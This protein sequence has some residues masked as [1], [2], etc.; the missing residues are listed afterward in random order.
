MYNALCCLQ[1]LHTM[2]IVHRD[3]KPA[4]LLIDSNCNIK[5]CDFGLSRTMPKRSPEEEHLKDLQ[6]KVRSQM[7]TEDRKSSEDFFRKTM[8]EALT[9]K[10]AE[11]TK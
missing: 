11:R 4:N 3:I 10:K 6:K 1:F 9:S 2:N 8:T 7:D 5:V